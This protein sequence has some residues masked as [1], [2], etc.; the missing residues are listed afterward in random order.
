MV[1]ICG[2]EWVEEAREW[3]RAVRSRESG[4]NKLF[5]GSYEHALDEKGRVS[6]PVRFREVLCSQGDSRLVIT[7]NL[8]SEGQCLVAYPMDQWMSFQE[9]V[10]AMP[11]FDRAVILLKRLH[12]AGAT[13]VTADRQGRILIPP[14]LREYAGLQSQ[15]LFAGLGEKIEI[16]DKDGWGQQRARARECREEINE[17]LARLGF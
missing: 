17:T 1:G 16:W 15:V 14:L 13:E 11:Q 7:T 4:E 2:E 6:L 12:I 3:G 8:D 9:K 5:L 10:A